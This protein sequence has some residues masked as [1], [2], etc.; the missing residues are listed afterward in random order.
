MKL[1]EKKRKA[2]LDAAKKSFLE[3]GFSGSNIQDIIIVAGVSKRTFYHHFPNKIVLFQTVL[4]EHWNAVIKIS[5]IKMEKN[6]NVKKVLKQFAKEFL[7]F[8]YAPESISFFR[9]LIAESARFPQLCQSLV[10]EGKAPFT[11]A[12]IDYLK[13]QKKKNQK[14]LKINNVELAASQ[15]MG[16][17]K[18][19]QFWPKLLGFI[20]TIKVEETQ[21]IIE[22]A[23]SVFLSA[24]QN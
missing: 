23:V 4:T 9:L 5:K 14:K 2:I 7:T 1:T 15:F 16:L 8:L 19:D 11:Q 3:L 10:S 6:E 17:L 13:G 20:P 12:L 22:S 24:Y 21:E 18:E